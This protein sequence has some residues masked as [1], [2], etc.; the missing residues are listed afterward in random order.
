MTD[1]V[2]RLR[3]PALIFGGRPLSPD[4]TGVYHGLDKLCTEAAD[5]IER[6]RKC[7]QDVNANRSKA[8]LCAG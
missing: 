4:D 2:E 5:E 8:K 1:I 3:L 7:L 6:L